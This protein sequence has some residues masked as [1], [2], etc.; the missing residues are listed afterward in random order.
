MNWEKVAQ[1]QASKIAVLE[2]EKAQY[3]V[4]TEDLQDRVNE[5]E[6]QLAESTE[7]G[8]EKGEQQ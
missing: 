8:K 6:S 3:E 1:K 4:L 5:L 2:F 7:P